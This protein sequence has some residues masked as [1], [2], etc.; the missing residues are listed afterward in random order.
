[1][2]SDPRQVAPPTTPPSSNEAAIAQAIQSVTASTQA[3]V[4]DQVDLAKIEM[5]TKAS[6]FGKGAA[7]GAAAGVF[8]LGA[9]IL[10]LHGFAWLAWYLI[11]P[12]EQFFWGFFLIAVLLLIMAAIAGFVAYKALQKAQSPVPDQALAAARETQATIQGET[13]LMKEQ[14]REAVV[15]PEDQRQ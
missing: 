5:Q 4:K 10:I 7:V 11:F 15:K 9:L 2:A 1:M 8:V 12:D 3:L 13:T 14:V 6:V